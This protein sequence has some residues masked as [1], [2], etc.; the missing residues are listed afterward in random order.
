MGLRKSTVGPT[1]SYAAKKQ[2]QTTPV[3]AALLFHDGDAGRAGQLA[4]LLSS[5]GVTVLAAG[6]AAGDADAVVVFLSA[7]GLESQEWRARMAAVTQISTRLIP[8]RVGKIDDRHVPERL[9]AL[10]WIDW[11]PGNVRGTFGYVVAGLFSDPARRDLSRLLSHEAEAWM[12]SG[13]RDALLIANYR[14]A[15]RM[16]A[17]LRD[18]EADKLAA[19][20]AVMGQYVQRSLK[21]SR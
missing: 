15:R 20:T 18:L 6:A 13:R 16:T 2:A 10:N 21:V 1:G 8:V 5:A 3:S 12:R 19:P 17:M 14:R 4:S 9:A 11:Q 7:T